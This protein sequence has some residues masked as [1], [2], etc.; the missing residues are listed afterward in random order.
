MYSSQRVPRE[1]HGDPYTD[2]AEQMGKAR[3][4]E[5]FSFAVCQLLTT[6]T[7]ERAA[8]LLSQDT[9]GRLQF[10]LE[11]LRPYLAELGAKA[12]LKGALGQQPPS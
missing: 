4:Q 3:R 6:G 10:V 2:V 5:L 1:A 9:A 11:A 12:S 7:P 8:L